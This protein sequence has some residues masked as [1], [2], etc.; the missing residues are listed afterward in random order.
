MLLHEGF[1]WAYAEFPALS[2]QQ[3][4]RGMVICTSET[5]DANTYLCWGAW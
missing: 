2:A 1:F 3:F 4:E 5:V